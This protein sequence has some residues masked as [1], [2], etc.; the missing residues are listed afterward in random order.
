MVYYC[1]TNIA[2]IIEQMPHIIPPEKV[3]ILYG[4]GGDW[5]HVNSIAA[6]RKEAGIKHDDI[7]ES[8]SPFIFNSPIYGPK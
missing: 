2:V 7:I 1:F 6:L 5:S 8:N 3:G 4:N